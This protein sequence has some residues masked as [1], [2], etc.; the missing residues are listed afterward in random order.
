MFKNILTVLILLILPALTFGTSQYNADGTPKPVRVITEVD[1]GPFNYWTSDTV[2]NIDG[3]VYVDDGEILMIEPG[4][5]IKGNPGQGEDATALIVARGGKIYALGTACDPIIFTS[6]SDDVDDPF[7]IPLNSDLGRGLWG[8]LIMLGNAIL[9]GTDTAAGIVR[10]GNIEGIPET[11]PRGVYGGT[12]DMDNSGVLKYVSVRH[13]GSEIGAANEINGVTM[14]AVGAGTIVDYVEVT[15]NLDDGFEWFGGTVSCY[16]LTVSSVGDDCFDMDEGY[17]GSGQ[18]W[19]A[20]HEEN[21]G[22]RSGEHDGTWGS[23]LETCPRSSA[24]ISNATYIG[25]GAANGG[26]RAFELRDNMSGAYYN[27]IITEHGTYG[28]NVE[29]DPAGSTLDNLKDGNLKLHNNVWYGFGDGNSSSAICNAV[30][31]VDT[32]LFHNYDPSTYW[33]GGGPAPITGT[34]NNLNYLSTT[35]V[36]ANAGHNPGDN[37]DPRPVNEGSWFTNDGATPWSWID[38]L[39]ADPFVGYHPEVTDVPAG[40][41]DANWLRAYEEVDYAGA[42]DPNSSSTWLHG[43]SALDQYGYLF[44]SPL[45][46]CDC[47]TD[48]DKEVVVVTDN[49][50]TEWTYFSND[51]VYNLDGFVYV[52]DGETLVIEPGTV[53]KG[54]PGQAENATALVVARGG[55]I[56]ALGSHCCPVVFTSISD[57]VDDPFDIPLD[58]DL[59]RGLWGGVI[60]LGNAVI[61]DTLEGNIEGIPETE[62]RGAYGGNDDCDNS[63][64]LRF[65]SIRH[66]GSEIGAANE[67]NGLTMGGVGAGTRIS[68]VE[69]FMNL[70]D[71]FEWFGGSVAV[72]HLIAA[73]CGDDAFDYDECWHTAP[74][75]SCDNVRRG[76]QYLFAVHGTTGGDRSGEHDGGYGSD[77]GACPVTTPLFS[78]VTYIGAGTE[79][80]QRCF[81]IRDAAGGGYWNSVFTDHGTYGIN[82]EETDEA[83]DSRQRL[84]WDQLRFYNNIWYGFGNGNTSAAIANNVNDVDSILFY[85]FDVQQ[86]VPDHPLS[87]D[88]N[89][90]NYLSCDGQVVR[91]VDRGQNGQLDPRVSCLNSTYLND[92]GDVNWSEWA[93]PNDPDL[94]KG[95]HWWHRL[96]PFCGADSVT[97]ENIVAEDF[98]GAF[99]PSLGHANWWT[100]G[101]AFMDCGGYLGEA[102]DPNCPD[103]GGATC[104]ILRGDIDHSGAGPDISDLVYLVS[105]MFSGGTPP[106]CVE[107]GVYLE[108]D[109]DGSGAGPDIS[110]LVYL[111]SY[112]FSGGPAPVPCP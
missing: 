91:N 84:Y 2:Y 59:G 13:G 6:I 64:V 106:P 39:D 67:I 47:P 98:P 21:N 103:C 5:I 92:S 53:I 48:D 100:T 45:A 63:G 108:A 3:F 62:P 58:D 105:Y 36:V 46:D 72:D 52:E 55:Q 27:S 57:D 95:Y 101:W 22:D 7:D 9:P 74:L 38:P 112:M 87:L 96:D 76:H 71:G 37:L 88:I 28:L 18:F 70:D 68:H 65:V 10:E 1:I 31:S 50:I 61:C 15:H 102:A 75:A 107:G 8:G 78:N 19:F 49:D 11:E 60:M 104:C 12:D 80:G 93:D 24:V 85:T 77:V 30:N 56:Y 34:K 89:H 14:G 109:V 17:R 4:T 43:W 33:L 90:H 16:H 25:R 54:N 82:V 111:V 20:I 29:D 66:G 32:I 69:V 97:Y 73:F 83:V 86:Y 44:D 23:E 41:I 94:V 40:C 26:Q 42:F 35:D 79:S 99:D 110:D 81:E 51:N